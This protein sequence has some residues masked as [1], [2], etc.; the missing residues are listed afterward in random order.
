MTYTPKKKSTWSILRHKG[1]TNYFSL[2]QYFFYRHKKKVR[3]FAPPKRK[4]L[5]HFQQQNNLFIKLLNVNY[6]EQ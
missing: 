5:L 3:N 2:E 1:V 4:C 6:D